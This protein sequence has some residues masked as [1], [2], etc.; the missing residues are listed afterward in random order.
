[1]LDPDSLKKLVGRKVVAERPFR[2]PCLGKLK[3]VNEPFL[4]LDCDGRSVI[5]NI[6]QEGLRLRPIDKNPPTKPPHTQAT[7]NARQTTGTQMPPG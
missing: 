5:L 7:P 6:G 3:S 4:F 1:V 2:E